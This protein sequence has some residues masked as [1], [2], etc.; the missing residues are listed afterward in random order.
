M[1]KFRA[2]PRLKP[3]MAINLVSH[4]LS[5]YTMNSPVMNAIQI[6]T[7]LYPRPSR[8]RLRTGLS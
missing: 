8:K 4:E 2:E 3:A 5:A 6:M 1:T 7:V